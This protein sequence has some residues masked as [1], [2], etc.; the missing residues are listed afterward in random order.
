MLKLYKKTKDKFHYWEI[1]ID[2]DEL[3]THWG[4]VGTSGTDKALAVKEG[5]DAEKILEREK[6]A[7]IADG[8]SDIAQNEILSITY[9]GEDFEIEE[10][11]DIRYDVEHLLNECLGWT[12]NGRCVGADIGS[13]SFTIK[14]DVID[15]KV[16]KKTAEDA[17][18]EANL[19]EGAHIET[20]DGK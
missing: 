17:L 10:N 13:R 5:E 11:L 15:S 20:R 16:A 14:C 1:W 18:R 7:K 6:Q 9:K 8:Y 19:L 2:G 4:E 3:V 12:G